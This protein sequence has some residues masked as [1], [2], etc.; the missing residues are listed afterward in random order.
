[1]FER[2][3]HVL[4]IVLTI[5]CCAL[6][7]RSFS[8]Q[9]VGQGK[10]T[11]IAKDASIDE[12]EIPT[13]RGRILD[14]K[15]REL[16]VDQPCIDACVQYYAIAASHDTKW[17]ANT[18]EGKWLNAIA[19]GRLRKR[20]DNYADLPLSQR[21]ALLAAE[22][23]QVKA[24]IDTM[25]HELA[26]LSKHTDDQIDEIRRQIV[27]RVETRRRLLWYRKYNDA[28]KTAKQPSFWSR[29]LGAAPAEL[30]S[31][32]VHVSEERDVHII[33]P[34]IDYALRNELARRA[35]N[36]PGLLL[37]EGVL[38]YYPYG[39]VACQTIGR[40]AK[41]TGE[42]LVK[43]PRQDEPRGKYAPTDEIG[44]DGMEKLFEPQLRGTRGLEAQNDID[45]GTLTEES[46]PVP[47]A[48][49]T[50][51]IDVELQKRVE[52]AFK[53]VEF[54]P[55]TP[56][57]KSYIEMP[58]AAVVIDVATG[59][60]RAMASWPTYDLNQFDDLFPKLSRD[61]INRPL[62]N[63]AT[64]LAVEPG[65][66]VK[67]VVGISAIS[68]GVFR[69]DETIAC[70]GYIVIDGVKHTK[71]GRCWT[72]KMHNGASHMTLANPPASPNLTFPEALQRSCNVFHEELAW[73]M[74]IDRL[75]EWF[76]KFGLGEPTGI[77]LLESSGLVPD[78]WTGPASERMSVTCSAGIGERFVHATPIQM[79]NVAATIA[80]GGTSLRPTLKFGEPRTPVDLHLNRQ[81][82]AEAQKGMYDVVNTPAGTGQNAWLPDVNVS[83]KTGSAQTGPL[84]T[85]QRDELLKPIRDENGRVVYDDIAIGTLEAPN[86]LVPWYRYTGSKQDTLPAH[87]WMIGFA[88]AEHPTVAF[89][90]LVEYGGGGGP[91][92][93][94]VVQKL[95]EAC[96]DQGYISVK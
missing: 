68:A 8:L 81:A 44:R 77:G 78:D 66:T 18:D 36:Y 75:S 23:T 38:R 32:D 85:P 73:R 33:L 53:K 30:D 16:A 90:V 72:A 25:W 57:P 12:R 27:R 62:Q 70:D 29:L 63:R 28:D 80:R 20:L 95:V 84:R 3:L 6:A 61:Q 87:G 43:D 64:T 58:G 14:V 31:F 91:A 5:V 83:A 47:G 76:R 7:L 22:A 13:V 92:A 60:V 94:S 11:E 93:G 86:P 55:G 1:M 50:T 52:E 69:P 24:D 56:V 9:V 51:T 2:R 49:V 71:W 15:G 45:N 19:R 21:K 48:D 79:A 37:R 82:V 26:V 10:W 34:N 35:G 89:A 88:P 96:K 46:P 40:T 41:V 42:D 59:E 74:G 54:A 4:L 67:P 17:A 65:S 39:S